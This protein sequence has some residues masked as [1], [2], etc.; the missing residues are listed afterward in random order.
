MLVATLTTSCTRDVNNIT[1]FF[2]LAQSW[3]TELDHLPMFE[4]NTVIIQF[5]QNNQREFVKRI[6][7]DEFIVPF[8]DMKC[9]SVRIAVNQY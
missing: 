8:P 6:F 3:P 7:I 1:T 2:D 9:R 4:K 5:K